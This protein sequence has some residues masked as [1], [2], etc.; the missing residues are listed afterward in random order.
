VAM[1]K[2]EISDPARNTLRFAGRPVRRLV[3]VL[4]ELFHSLHDENGR[5]IWKCLSTHLGNCYNKNVS[6]TKQMLITIL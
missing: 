1:A 6:I 3:T 2:I 4:T 5:L